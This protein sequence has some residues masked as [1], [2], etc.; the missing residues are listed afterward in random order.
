MNPLIWLRDVWE[1]INKEPPV[2]R[3]IL[4]IC[5]SVVVIPLIIPVALFFLIKSLFKPGE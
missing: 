5:F 2:V 1:F 3:I 4:I